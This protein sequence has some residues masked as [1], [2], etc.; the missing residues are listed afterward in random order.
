LGDKLSKSEAL[1]AQYENI[2]SENNN[3][4]SDKSATNTE[5]KK[6]KKNLK[7]EENRY[8]EI[9]AANKHLNDEVKTLTIENKK[10]GN[11]N[12]DMKIETKEVI[13]KL[14]Q[15]KV[16]IETELR[17][18]TA[19]K[20]E[21]VSSQ[22]DQH[23]EIPYKVTSVLPPIFSS[24]VC[25]KSRPLHLSNSLPSL[26]SICWCKPNENFE[27]EAEEA[28]VEQYDR[29]V[30]EF[31]EDERDRLL[32]SREAVHHLTAEQVPEPHSQNT[33]DSYK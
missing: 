31:Y 12:E 6:L 29:Q 26:D 21:E 14:K 2:L 4:K 8:L 25:W 30:H 33:D 9:G 16:D 18:L 32:A 24:Q 19:R 27:D 1:K 3:L 22:T 11:L 20:S 17:F 7:K 5:F 15:E 23:P 10:L 28:L 13:E